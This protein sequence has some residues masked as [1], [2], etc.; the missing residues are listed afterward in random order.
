MKRPAALER[1]RVTQYVINLPAAL[2]LGF[3][4]DLSEIGI[5][6]ALS[7]ARAGRVPVPAPALAYP[8]STCDEGW[9]GPGSGPE[10]GTMPAPRCCRAGIT[11]ALALGQAGSR[12]WVL[13]FC[14]GGGFAATR[15]IQNPPTHPTFVAN[16]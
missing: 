10:A 14:F 15:N 13:I 9:H 3:S 7:E 2:E 12:R 6:P 4:L 8:G 1:E 11:P 5:M 16:P